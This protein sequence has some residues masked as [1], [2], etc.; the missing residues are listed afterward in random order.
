[1]IP[2]LTLKTFSANLT[3]LHV[4]SSRS[5]CHLVDVIACCPQLTHFSSSCY[6]HFSRKRNQASLDSSLRLQY[7]RLKHGISM[8]ELSSILRHSPNLRHMRLKWHGHLDLIKVVNIRPEL[9]YLSC[10]EFPS[11]TLDPLWNM[12]FPCVQPTPQTLEIAAINYESP[13]HQV[14]A[15]LNS[16]WGA[17]TKR[18]VCEISNIFTSHEEQTSSQQQHQ[19]TQPLL[20]LEEL[21]YKCNK[22]WD[23]ETR[24]NLPMQ[25]LLLPLLKQGTQL[26]HVDIRLFCRRRPPVFNSGLDSQAMP[27]YVTLSKLLHLRHLCIHECNSYY[28]ESLEYLFSSMVLEHTP[29]QSFEYMVTRYYSDVLCF[30]A[31]AKVPTI[32]HVTLYAFQPTYMDCSTVASFVKSLRLSPSIDSLHFKSGSGFPY[33]RVFKYLS[34][35]MS[36]RIK[37]LTFSS[38]YQIS[39]SGLKYLIEHHPQIETLRFVDVPGTGTEDMRVIIPDLR[40]RGVK[41]VIWE[42]PYPINDC[43]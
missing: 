41:N 43:A 39:H 30:E 21:E 25:M 33:E 3:H 17:R 31:L 5:D 14:I 9:E 1:M 35:N 23:M 38:V 8:D 6:V 32:R 2:S 26:K 34:D 42:M 29:L 22:Y 37:H 18:L 28:P 19:F 10:D 20:E 7:L 27:E 12:P 11:L 4:G 36:N 13:I 15:L 40:A 24:Y 16:S